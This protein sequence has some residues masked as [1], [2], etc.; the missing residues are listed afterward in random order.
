MVVTSSIKAEISEGVPYLIFSRFFSGT[1][2]VSSFSSA[3]FAF[4]SSTGL[5]L[6]FAGTVEVPASEVD[7]LEDSSVF[8]SSKASS[9]SVNSSSE[10][11]S[12]F[13]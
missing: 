5:G 13:F 3:A 10:G 4:S 6:F 9:S 8:S 12:S 11:I 7:F 2:G 1:S